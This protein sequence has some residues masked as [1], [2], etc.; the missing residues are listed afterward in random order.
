M[1]LTLKSPKYGVKE[2]LIDDEDYDKIKGYIWHIYK[3][4]YTFYCGTFYKIDGK[5]KTIDLHRFLTN[6]PKGFDV[7]HINRDGLD[8]RRSN[9]RICTRSQNIQNQKIHKDNR[10]GARGLYWDKSRKKW[11]VRICI[12]YK[13]IHIGRFE[14]KEDAINAYNEAAKKYHGEF[15]RVS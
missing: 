1:I 7:D 2:V 6:C 3:R 14:N 5:Q 9:L 15:A 11:Q 12:N 8:N 4:P 13:T 10:Y